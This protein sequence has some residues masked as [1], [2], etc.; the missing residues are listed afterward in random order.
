LHWG[1]GQADPA[2]GAQCLKTIAAKLAVN[3]RDPKDICI[4]FVKRAKH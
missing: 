4:A 3:K 2:N 1:L